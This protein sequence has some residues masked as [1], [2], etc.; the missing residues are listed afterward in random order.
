MVT[1]SPEK[2][3]KQVAEIKDSEEYSQ[4]NKQI[5]TLKEKQQTIQQINQLFEAPIVNGNELKPAILAADQPISVKKLTGNDPF[6]QLMNQAID[7]ANQQYNQLQKAKKAVEV[8]YKDGKT[9]NQLNRDTY[10]AA[11]AE[12]DKVTSDKLKK[13]LVKQV[14]TADQALT[15]VEEEQKRI[16]EEQAAAEQ[17]KQAEEQAKQ[18]EEQAK[19][20]EEQAK[21][22]AAAKKEN[23]KKEETAKTEANGYTAPNSDGVYTSPLYAP[24][25]ADI[26]D[27]SNPAWTW[28]PGVKEKVLDTVIARGYVVPGGYSLEPAKIVNGEG[29]YNLYATN[30]QS[31]LLEGTTEKN[32]HMYLVTINAKTGWFKGNAS[33][34]AGQ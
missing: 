25:A 29:Y 17:A 16:A 1:V 23:A 30:N 15:K 9:T 33:R 6:D 28:A 20:A 12:V 8:I 14:T 24:D 32:V 4:L 31:K 7:Q 22:A 13:E 27:S 18:A 10:Q 21:Q 34:N 3:S 19:Q 11:K 2:L 26:A 5:Q